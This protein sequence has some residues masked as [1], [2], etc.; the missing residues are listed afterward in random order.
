MVFANEESCTLCQSLV[1]PEHIVRTNWRLRIAN[2][3]KVSSKFGCVYCVMCKTKK[4]TKKK[5]LEMGHG[6]EDSR[7]STREASQTLSRGGWS[8]HHTFPFATLLDRA[9]HLRLNCPP[10]RRAWSGHVLSLSII[11]TYQLQCSP[12][13]ACHLHQAGYRRTDLQPPLLPRRWERCEDCEEGGGRRER[14]QTGVMLAHYKGGRE[15]YIWVFLSCVVALGRS[16]IVNGQTSFPGFFLS[17]VNLTGNSVRKLHEASVFANLAAD[18]G[19]L[20]CFM[21]GWI[22][23]G[24]R[25]AMFMYLFEHFCFFTVHKGRDYAESGCDVFCSILQMIV[26]AKYSS[27]CHKVFDYFFI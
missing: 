23:Q 22:P 27:I 11:R 12:R 14:R 6:H 13:G 25:L 19:I 5:T 26:L 16:R 3:L 4:K 10:L 9:G 18:F 20:L 24:G 15:N 7:D 2:H 8:F 21:L 1:Q 17:C